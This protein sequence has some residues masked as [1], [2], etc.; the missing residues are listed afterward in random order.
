[1]HDGDFG[2]LTLVFGEAQV[3]GFKQHLVD[4]EDYDTVD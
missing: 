1:M 3:A 4:V 2:Q